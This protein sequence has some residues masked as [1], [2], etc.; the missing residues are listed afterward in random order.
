MNLDYQMIGKLLLNY[1]ISLQEKHSYK[2]S[3]V[4]WLMESNLCESYSMSHT[5]AIVLHIKKKHICS[6]IWKTCE[7]MCFSYIK[8]M[9][10]MC[11]S[12][13]AQL[14][15]YHRALF[16]F[17]QSYTIFLNKITKMVECKIDKSPCTVH[18]T[19]KHV[20]LEYIILNISLVSTMLLH[21]ENNLIID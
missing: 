4:E 6:N 20:Y 12:C 5:Q 14:L 10:F 17:M 18:L 19:K 15:V 7:N 2:L 3:C 16:I 1:H 11:F 13:V 9:F 8:F 21:F